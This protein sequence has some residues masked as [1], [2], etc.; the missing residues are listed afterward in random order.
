VVHARS[1]LLLV[2]DCNRSALRR[3]PLALLTIRVSFGGAGIRPAPAAGVVLEIHAGGL[4]VSPSGTVEMAIE[5][6]MRPIS[7]L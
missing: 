4:A 1:L 3:S 2:A 5:F 6:V 7:G